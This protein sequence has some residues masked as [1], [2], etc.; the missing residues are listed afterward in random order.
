L[1]EEKN[2]QN[3]LEELL[4]LDVT[5]YNIKSIGFEKDDDSNYHMDFITSTSNIRATS[6]S[7]PNEDKHKTK[8]IA[9]NIIPAMITTTA[10]ATGLVSFELYKLV[11]KKEKS[12]FFNHFMNTSFNIFQ[13]AEPSDAPKKF[14]DRWDIWDRFDI[15]EGKDITMN[16]LIKIIKERYDLSIVG[17]SFD[18]IPLMVGSSIGSTTK[19]IPISKLLIDNYDYDFPKRKKYLDLTIISNDSNGSTVNC[20]IVKLQFKFDDKKKI[21]KKN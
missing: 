20:P 15:N 12:F 8:G 14:S 9:G 3:A 16:E 5:K 13:S 19:D 11:L 17:I 6:Y 21:L 10:I 4:N 2:Y 1:E 18:G 7:I